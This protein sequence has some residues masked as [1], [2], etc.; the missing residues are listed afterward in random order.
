[1]IDLSE[2]SDPMMRQARRAFGEWLGML[3]KEQ[4][5]AA[6]FIAAQEDARAAFEVIFISGWLFATMN[7]AK[8]TR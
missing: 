2:F 1:M 4:P 8:A 7:K 6:G 3:D 5:E